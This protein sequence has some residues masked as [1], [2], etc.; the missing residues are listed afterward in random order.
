MRLASQGLEP[1]SD[2]D[3]ASITR[4][5][6]AIQAQE[7]RSAALALF[8]R[9]TAVTGQGVRTA[10]VE[11]RSIVR[12][13]AM[14]RTLHIVPTEDLPWL[15]P[16]L[17]SRLLPR[18]SAR[19]EQLGVDEN[20]CERA[21]GMISALLGQHGPLT[22]AE[23]V[24][25]LGER[26]LD[27]SG[28]RAPWLLCR[29]ALEGLICHG[30]EKDR[31]ASFVLLQDWVRESVPARRSLSSDQALAELAGRYL[32][33]HQPASP[34]DFSA[35]SGLPIRD[36]RAGWNL[37]GSRLSNVFVNGRTMSVLS[38][39]PA[40]PLLARTPVVRLLPRFDPYLLGYRDRSMMIDQR[41]AKL[42]NAGGGMPK[43]TIMVDGR[44][45]G[46]WRY[47]FGRTSEIHLD[48][49]S[50]LADAV[51]PGLHLEVQAVESFLDELASE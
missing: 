17:A 50:P 23:I 6:G 12:T 19:L 51:L 44:I 20:L 14:R 7:V 13:W 35:W 34:A 27:A 47:R 3:P 10:L 8:V 29:A 42:I 40:R 36:A 2:S 32:A 25:E 15:L 33:S 24:H 39:S 30:P 18:V 45:T 43:P 1:R 22:R 16:L 41:K 31:T 26:D 11:D 48:P 49:F 46:T 4:H 38:A 28:Q 37:L 21:V 5:L 9:G